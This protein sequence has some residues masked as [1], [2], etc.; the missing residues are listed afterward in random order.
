MQYLPIVI[1]ISVP[2][3]HFVENIFPRSLDYFVSDRQYQ[4]LLPSSIQELNIT[5]HQLVF[6]TKLPLRLLFR[7]SSN[8]QI[9]PNS[10]TEKI[11]DC[12][13]RRIGFDNRW[14]HIHRTETHL[15]RV[16]WRLLRLD[17]IHCDCAGFT[18]SLTWWPQS[19]YQQFMNIKSRHFNLVN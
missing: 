19:P 9:L 1:Q 16:V 6:Y 11:E 10:R 4:I 18:S 17:V 14:P 2:E 5:W 15:T 3:Q 13:R 12:S 7:W 8:S